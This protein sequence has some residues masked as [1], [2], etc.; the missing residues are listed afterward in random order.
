M[1]QTVVLYHADC[2]D[3]FGAAWAA[4]KKFG[5]R[6]EYIPLKAGSTPSQMK[7]ISLKKKEVYFLD[8]CASS[9]VL[10]NL[11]REN[12][13]VTVIDHHITNKEKVNAASGYVFDVTRSAAILAWR[14]FHPKK[15]VPRLL[16]YI[17]DNDL[18]NYREPHAKEVGAAGIFLGMNFTSWNAWAKQIENAAG[19]KKIVEEGKLI[20]AHEGELIKNILE[21][22]VPVRFLGHRTLAVNSSVLRSEIGHELAK[23]CPPLGIVWRQESNGVVHVSLRSEGKIDVS[24]LAKRFP[25]GGGHPRAAGFSVASVRELSWK[26]IAE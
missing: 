5:K 13:S 21:L 2:Q 15:A 3:G 25:G 26:L 12:R 18:W 14:Y 23:Q 1:K 16:R 24:K 6:A 9:D 19:L 8:V 20:L 4:W 22:A 17:E 10:K 11:V 7:G